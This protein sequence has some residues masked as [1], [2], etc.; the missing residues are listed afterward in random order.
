MIFVDAN[1]FMYAVGR[2]HPLLQTA[3]A[4]FERSLAE[5]EPLATSAEVLQELLHA[6]LPTDRL[7]DFDAALDL[8]SSRMEEI[9]PIEAADVRFARDLS[10]RHTALTA[11]DVLHLATCLRHGADRI[12]T[13][14]RALAAA[15]E[16]G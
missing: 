2:P 4:F 7:V 5:R 15:W 12:E 9:W 6:Y 14:D 13:F 11:R 1:A 10:A 8:A 16:P 3:R